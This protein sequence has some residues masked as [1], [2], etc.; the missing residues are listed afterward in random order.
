MFGDAWFV[1][2]G[3]QAYGPWTSEEIRRQVQ[4]G[5]IRP[6]AIVQKKGEGAW[7][8]LSSTG[9]LKGLA[10]PPVPVVA[11]EAPGP[12][13]AGPGAP[14]SPAGVAP[15]PFS[16]PAEAPF[17]G[18]WFRVA[19]NLLDQIVL[20]V[21]LGIVLALLGLAAGGAVSDGVLVS[22]MVLIRVICLSGWGQTPGMYFLGI[23][24]L[25]HSS[26]S[27]PSPGQV[28]GREAF[29]F[30][31]VI[32]ALAALLLGSLSGLLTGREGF[33]F[34]AFFAGIVGFLTVYA[35]FVLSIANHPQ[36]R[37]WHDRIAGTCVVHVR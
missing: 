21:P 1:R 17:T 16:F 9:I 26:G 20:G 28:I 7:L 25:S 2:Q 5:N 37:G 13:P 4:V 31:L 18:F 11:P 10:L 27:I 14:S 15:A 12:E 32:P 35:L 8:L 6:D 24:L 3:G 19:A 30:A 22:V 34:L 36:K 29:F 33:P 23:Q